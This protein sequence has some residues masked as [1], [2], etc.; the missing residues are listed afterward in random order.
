MRPYHS[1]SRILIFASSIALLLV[2]SLFFSSP[3]V[4]AIPV[5]SERV[6]ILQSDAEGIVLELQVPLY[7]V[8]IMTIDGYT[9]QRLSIEGYGL[10]GTPGEPE[11]PQKGLLLGIP[12]GAQ[13]HLTVL[14]TESTLTKGFRIPPAPEIKIDFTDPGR[15]PL[16]EGASDYQ[17]RFNE[18]QSVYSHDAFFPSL[19]AEIGDSGYLRDQRYVQVLV[20]PVQ[21]NPVTG[22]LKHHH[23]IKLQVSFSH[24]QGRLS[25]APSRAESPAFETVLKNSILNYETA[26]PWRSSPPLKVQATSAPLD[27]LTAPSYK[28][29]VAQDGIYQ[30][31]YSDLQTAGLPVDSLD[32]RTFQLYNMGSEVAIYVEGEGDKSFDSGDYILFYGQKMNTKYTNTNVYWL[33]YGAA[34]GRRMDPKD[35]MP[36][37]AA[38]PVAFK[39]TVHLEEDHW[40]ISNLPMQ[41]GADHWYWNYY[42]PP[43][44][45][46]QSYAVTLNNIFTDTYTCTLRAR[47]GGGTSDSS[48]D[49]DHHLKLY[50]NNQF[51]GDAYWDGRTV[52]MGEYTFPQSYLVEGNNVVKIVAPKDTGASVDV[53]YINWLEIEYYDTY[54]AEGN[55]LHFNG[56]EAGTWEYHVGGFT[57][58][59]IEAFDV[60]DP[61]NVSR[62]INAVIEPGSSYTLK[63]EDTITDRTEY[64]ALTTAQRLSPLSIA[65]DTPSDLHATSNGADYIIITHSAFAVHLPGDRDDI[66]DLES[67]RHD[68]GLHTMVVDVQDV[69]DEF[70]YGVF[71][72]QAIHDFLAYA[73]ANW[74][75]PAPSY[76]LLVGDGNL[77]FKDNLG[78]HEAN[79]IPPYLA[80]VDPNQFGETAADNRYVTV[81]GDDILPDMHIGRLPVQTS[82]QASTMVNK[83]LNYE[84]NPASGDWNSKALFVADEQPD[85][86]GAGN[87]WDLSDD[88][89]TNYLP[90]AYMADKVYYDP[91][92]PDDPTPPRPQPPYYSN[93][94]NVQAAIVAAI[95]DGH[96]LVNYIGHGAFQYWAQKQLFRIADLAS[97]TNSEK[98]PMML[99]MTCQEGYFHYP[100]YPCLGESI[101]RAD[102]KGAIASWSATGW[103]M[104]LGHHYLDQGFFTAVFN[105]K[106]D[107]GTA[108]YLGKLNLYENTTGYRDLID[109]YVLLGDPFMKLDLPACDAADLDNDGRITVVDI[110]QVAA[111]WGTQ[112]GDENYDRKYDLDDDGP[113]TVADIMRVA[114]QWRKTC[115]TP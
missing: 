49:P 87:F 55:R 60:T 79:Y 101:V 99:P 82:A 25:L 110:M 41:E 14:E 65:L 16:L 81:N 73:Y 1:L 78:T 112:W 98:L 83:I 40:Y 30:L 53:G 95:N 23:Y 77:D 67:R 105:D 10:G 113:I 76:V 89:A 9:Y 107:I 91:L 106:Q 43:S 72:P 114:T 45:P 19:V 68:Q 104:A 80:M 6:R 12:P 94:S 100:N 84:Q 27:Y 50:V 36:A 63:F 11:L 26:K 96:L 8:Q 74:Q 86:Q 29:S 2:G 71:D 59:D 33:R 4:Q 61:A 66:Y 46:T 56:D 31:T 18:N 51:V 115:A 7:T 42:Y 13:A 57:N 22:E 85:P 15:D 54:M 17:V 35:G 62:I 37:E 108:T 52:Y 109:T 47:I 90:S 34:D 5:G 75:P 97:L 102:G 88:I 58:S 64:M 103:G 48:V 38:S 28:I 69:Y 44:V 93:A 21:Y 39:N 24:P 20:N 92:T 3:A 111:H 32:P 70:S